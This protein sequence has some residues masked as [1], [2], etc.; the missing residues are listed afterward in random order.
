MNIVRM[1]IQISFLYVLYLLGVFIQKTFHLFIPGSII[2]MLLL[3]ILLLTNVIKQ[4]WIKAGSL[5]LIRYLPLFFVPVTVGIMNYL[6]LFKG[7]GLVIIVIV[8]ISTI[9]VMMGTGWI[10]QWLVRRQEE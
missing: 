3:F 4:D 6:D 1:I 10:S 8:L 5:L 9:L 7:K 2:G